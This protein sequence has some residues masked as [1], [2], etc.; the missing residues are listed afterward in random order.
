MIDDDSIAQQRQQQC[1]PPVTRFVSLELH[2]PSGQQRPV[3]GFAS[4]DVLFSVQIPFATLCV[5]DDDHVI[6]LANLF[7]CRHDNSSNNASLVSSA[8]K[9]SSPRLSSSFG[10]KS[11]LSLSLSSRGKNL[12]KKVKKLRRLEFCGAIERVT[13]VVSEHATF[14]LYPC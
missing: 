1:S 11:K 12:E 4:P 13:L 10:F 9:E 2:W 14:Y 5:S 3:F 7:I 6:E 8:G